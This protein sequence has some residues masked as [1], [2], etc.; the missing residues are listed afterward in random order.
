MRFDETGALSAVLWPAALEHDGRVHIV[1]DGARDHRIEPL[2]RSSRADYDCLYSGELSPRL[3]AAAPWLV[4]L[5]RTAPF[6]SDLIALGWGRSW[7]I[8]AMTREEIALGALRRHFRRFLKVRDE[9]GHT[10]LFRYYD[11][12]VL[13]VY[14]PTCTRQEA[15]LFF[16]PVERFVMEG[17]SPSDVLSF[18]RTATGVAVQQ[19]D[20]KVPA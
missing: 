6:T 19:L 8:F 3:H 9:Q 4:R 18:E 17:P 5:S 20:L 7:G 12:R 14:L 13:R 10:L 2:V 11:P 15:E 16:G 1:L